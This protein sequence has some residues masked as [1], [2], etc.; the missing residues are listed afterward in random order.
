MGRHLHHLQQCHDRTQVGRLETYDG[1]LVENIVQAVTREL[2][3]HA[4]T[5]VAQAGHEIIIHVHGEIGID[6]PEDSCFTLANACQLMTTRPTRQ[7]DCHSTPTGTNTTTTARIR[8]ARE[9][10]R[11][12]CQV[13]LCEKTARSDC[14]GRCEAASVTGR[15]ET[16]P[17]GG[18]S[19]G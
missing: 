10:T 5:L 4:M 8:R 13:L 9:A 2:L 3:V 1:K 14:A 7:Q 19:I 15:L 6:E 17:V 16:N 18:A 11:A 12:S